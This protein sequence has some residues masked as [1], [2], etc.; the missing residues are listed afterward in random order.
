[1]IRIITS[2]SELNDLAGAGKLNGLFRL[3]MDLYHAGPGIS[4]SGL[5][6]ILKS[7]AHYQAAKAEPQADT[8][9]LRFGRLVH[10]RLLEPDV[11][12]ATAYVRREKPKE[13]ERP[14]DLAD[15]NRKSKAGKELLDTWEASW[16]PAY[17]Q[18]LIDW[19]NEGQG[20]ELMSAS[21]A[22]VI[23][24]IAAVA[25]KN[26]LASAIFSR[27]DAEVSCYWT[28][29]ATG[30]LCKARADFMRDGTIFD[31]KTCY[32]AQPR[33]FRNA[34][35]KYRYDL[36]A[37]FYIDG[38]ETV[39]P[40]KNFAWIAVESAAPHCIGFYAA[41]AETL[42]TGR[43]D[44]RRALETFAACEKSGEWPGYEQTFLNLSLAGA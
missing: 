16:R 24:N 5:K 7:P 11:F 22:L 12:K 32:N 9:S 2:L 10:M 20:K 33:E 43:S 1:M 23:E 30:V 41:D 42:A 36:S 6:E 39:A 21:E 35:A 29:E 44:Y 25:E 38:F 31:L 19:E 17:A 15:V 26:K 37:A 18:S 27:G 28:D 13:P 40:V 4:S 14:A 8:T 34:V 3:P